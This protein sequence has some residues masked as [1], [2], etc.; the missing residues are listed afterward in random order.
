MPKAEVIAVGVNGFTDAHLL[1]RESPGEKD[2]IYNTAFTA[3]DNLEL[4]KK[5]QTS[6]QCSLRRSNIQMQSGVTAWCRRW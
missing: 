1:D 4:T 3:N 5:A 6:S 2:E